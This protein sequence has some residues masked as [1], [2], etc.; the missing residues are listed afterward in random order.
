MTTLLS[1][2]DGLVARAAQAVRVVGISQR[3]AK[4]LQTAIDP[5]EDGR[6]ATAAS[7]CV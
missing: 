5:A 3:P 2:T 1:L 7:T 4:S 6:D